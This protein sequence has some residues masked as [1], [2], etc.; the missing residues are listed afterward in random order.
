MSGD[1]A[2][3][4][5]PLDDPQPVHP[6]YPLASKGGVQLLAL[7]V[8]ADRVWRA[9]TKPQRELLLSVVAGFPIKARADVT[10][11]LV[12]H[13]LVD[14]ALSATEAGRLVVRWRS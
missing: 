7:M 10:A 4:A 6:R 8:N 9:L 3:A 14:D 2:V 11:R 13:G 5:V 12:G 1:W